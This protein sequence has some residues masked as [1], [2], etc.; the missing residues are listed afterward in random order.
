MLADRQRDRH[1]D[2]VIANA[3]FSVGR[4]KKQPISSGTN[5]RTLEL[6]AASHGGMAP[7]VDAEAE[8]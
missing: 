2:T 3:T 6:Y 5:R 8:E 4:F 1:T 7:V